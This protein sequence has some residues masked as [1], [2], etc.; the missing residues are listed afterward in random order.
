[1]SRSIHANQSERQRRQEG[2]IDWDAVQTKRAVKRAVLRDR[3]LPEEPLP[4]SSADDVPIHV[5]DESPCLFYPASMED[6]RAVL[7]AL[8]RGVTTGLTEIRL[9]TG[10]AVVNERALDFDMIEPHFGRQSIEAV[11]GVFVPCIQG[12]YEVS[13]QAIHI[14]GY[15]KAPGLKLTHRQQTL[16]ELEML[17]CLVHEVIHHHDRM[18][19]MGGGRTWASYDQRT[20]AFTQALTETWVREAVLPLLRRK[21]GEADGLRLARCIGKSPTT[22]RWRSGVSARERRRAFDARLQSL[23][24]HTRRWLK[25][26]WWREARQ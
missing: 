13:P 19:R 22:K 8:P 10:L 21:Y 26:S 24:K 6:M 16:L 11:P 15:S 7:R 3:V 4:I 25:R 5:V 9:G 20:E 18:H 1:M 12:I 2:G 14:H 23:P 17:T